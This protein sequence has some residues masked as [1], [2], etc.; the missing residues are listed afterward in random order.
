MEKKS[1]LV[2]IISIVTVLLLAAL[3]GILIYFNLPAQRIRRML[4]SANKYIAEE[5]YDEAILTLQKMIEID[6]KNENLY[7]LLASTYEKNGE[8]D[9]EISILQEAVEVLPEAVNL[10]D[11][12]EQAYTNVIISDSEESHFYDADDKSVTGWQSVNGSWK[13]LNNDGS[14]VTSSWYCIDDDNDGYG[15]WYRFDENGN[16]L[17]DTT[18]DNRKINSNGAWYMGEETNEMSGSVT[19]YTPIDASISGIYTYQYNINDSGKWT[20]PF[21]FEYNSVIIEYIDNNHIKVTKISDIRDDSTG[22]FVSRPTSEIYSRVSGSEFGYVT[23]TIMDGYMS[24]FTINPS[25]NTIVFSGEEDG[26]S[27]YA[28]TDSFKPHDG[29]VGTYYDH[30]IEDAEHDVEFEVTLNNDNTYGAMF[31]G[32]KRGFTSAG[33]YELNGN[34]LVFVT[35]PEYGGIKY[36]DNEDIYIENGLIYFAGH[37]FSAI[38][39]GDPYYSESSTY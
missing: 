22:G 39:R 18:I 9:K 32:G 6:P 4:K 13:Y 10:S 8:K 33:T 29:I 36:F 14:F 25:T 38:Y 15:K 28:K 2:L 5:N 26:D 31:F 12:L 1:N 17:T 23:N 27:Y 35:D 7:I 34:K 24:I 11:A 21:N 20:R 19:Q 30:Y 16:M 3:V 37:E